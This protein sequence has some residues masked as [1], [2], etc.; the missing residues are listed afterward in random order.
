MRTIEPIQER[1]SKSARR[2]LDLKVV[3]G[4]QRLK[5]VSHQENNGA[6]SGAFTLGVTN[7][8]RS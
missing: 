6:S 1:G 7:L 3:M 2:S 8:P 4:S 5:K